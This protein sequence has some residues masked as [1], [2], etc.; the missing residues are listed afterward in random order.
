MKN[1]GLIITLSV[2]GEHYV[3]DALAAT[4]V[5][6]TCGVRTEAIIKGLATF[7]GVRRR[8]DYK[9]KFAGSDVYDDYAHHPAEIKTTLSGA[10]K[11]GYSRLWCVYQ[12][13][14][15]SRTS[16]LYD[17]FIDVFKESN[18]NIIFADIYAARETNKWGVSSK[19]LAKDIP[20]SFY[21]S[22]NGEIVEYLRK[23]VGEK[24]A[25]IV[26]GAGDIYHIFDKMG[27]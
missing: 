6:A 9:G 19:Q 18:I 20:D 24:D 27:L 22:T 16:L 23:N 12:P 15:Y 25:I 8:M 1:K 7:C 21:F 2:I 10:K 4:A 26:M 14:T 13:H 17:E 5:A 11:M 3:K